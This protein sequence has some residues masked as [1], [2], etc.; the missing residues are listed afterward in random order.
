M[1]KQPDGG[2]ITDVTPYQMTLSAMVIPWGVHATFNVAAGIGLALVGAPVIALVWATTLCVV[3][4]LLQRLY[5]AWAQSAADLDSEAGLRRLS[6]TVFLRTCLWFIAPLAHALAS[7]TPSSFAFVTVTAVAITALG[8][9]F[10]WTSR[11]M[12]LAMVGPAVLAV[13]IATVA[14][15]EGPAALGVLVSLASLAATLLLI[16]IGTNKNV[17]EWSHA[18]RR[19]LEVLAEMKAALAR[20]EAAERRLRVAMD[21]TD[22][23]VYEVDYQTRELISLGA[24]EAFYETPLTYSQFW[25]DPWFAV[26]PDDVQGA[27]AAWDRYEAGKEPYKTEY[28]MKRSDGR[29]V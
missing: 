20:S 7:P 24:E 6:G 16:S 1:S 26:S 18:N 14:R 5:R 3:D 23:Y 15:L 27:T 2:L 12:F 9:S 8:V 25:N 11:R 21:I 19:T 4:A 10:G 17:S 13:A 29:E 28:R 22:L